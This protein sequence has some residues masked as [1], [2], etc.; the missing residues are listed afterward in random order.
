MLLDHSKR[1][2]IPMILID[3]GL[4]RCYQTCELVTISKL[5]RVISCVD[6]NNVDEHKNVEDQVN[7][8]N[9]VVNVKSCSYP[10]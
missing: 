7:G 8:K 9:D 10:Y 3:V 6:G 1:L 4:Y 2:I 5:S